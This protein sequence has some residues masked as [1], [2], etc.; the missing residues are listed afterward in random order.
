MFVTSHP[1]INN[2][3]PQVV[4]GRAEIPQT[5]NRRGSPEESIKRRAMWIN[6]VKR[7]AVGSTKQGVEAFTTLC[8]AHFISE[9]VEVFRTNTTTCQTA[10]PV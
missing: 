1:L 3:K 7:A 9:I 6:T 8:S 2:N 10:E 4:L 5:R